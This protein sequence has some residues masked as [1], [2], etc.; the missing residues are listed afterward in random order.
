MTLEQ[1]TG[2]ATI[3]HYRW[4]RLSHMFGMVVL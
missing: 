2:L 3:A 1:D 4:F